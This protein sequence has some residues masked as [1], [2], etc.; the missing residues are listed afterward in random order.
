MI[1]PVTSLEASASRYGWLGHSMSAV[2]EKL[3]L[4]PWTAF[5]TVFG[6]MDGAVYLF[7]LGILFLFLP[8]F[9]L[10]WL[11]PTAGDLLANLL[12]A[13]PMPRNIF[14]YHSVT[15][16][17]FL[18]IAAIFGS[19]QLSLLLKSFSIENILKLTLGLQLLLAYYVAPLPLPGA[20][21]Y[22]QPARVMAPFDER[23]IQVK[24]IVGNGTVSV[25]ANLGAHF[26][27]RH[28]IYSFP[29]HI[30]RADFIVLWLD[31]PTHRIAPDDP[32]TFGTE[33]HHRHLR[34]ADYLDQVVQL[35]DDK[36]YGLVYWNDP[37]L[38]FGKGQ[39]I[40]PAPEEQVRTKIQSLRQS[41]LNTWPFEKQTLNLPTL[42]S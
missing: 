12:S 23:E 17:P 7:G 1:K 15:L 38:V 16:I 30:D 21:N 3:I 41:W 18:T 36:N 26:S 14:S 2:L 28:S 37:W 31:S 39:N 25:Q 20:I 13:N 35:L 42:N 11:I 19:M 27:Q 6:L 29:E 10:L 5:K 33:A 24:Q 9:A 40:I 4:H 22:W 34:A 32:G 8:A